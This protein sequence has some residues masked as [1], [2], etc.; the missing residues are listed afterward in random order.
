MLPLLYYLCDWPDSIPHVRRWRLPEAIFSLAT[1]MV[2]NWAHEKPCH[3]SDGSRRNDCPIDIAQFPELNRARIH[4]RPLLVPSAAALLHRQTISRIISIP[5]CRMQKL[6]FFQ[7][8]THLCCRS[9]SRDTSTVRLCSLP[10]INLHST[11]R[12]AVGV[13]AQASAYQLLPHPSPAALSAVL[14]KVLR[15]T[16]AL[17]VTWRKQRPKLNSSCHSSPQQRKVPSCPF[18]ESHNLLFCTNHLPTAPFSALF[19]VAPRVPALPVARSCS[20]AQAAG[21]A[22]VVWRIFLRIRLTCL[23]RT[24]T[25]LLP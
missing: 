25:I 10:S 18:V 15:S 16:A 14:L 24:G 3:L 9:S 21:A 1:N 11:I 5:D 6:T 19:L 12:I 13:H 17:G 4:I 2:H 22:P 23:Q 7:A 20:C 8:T